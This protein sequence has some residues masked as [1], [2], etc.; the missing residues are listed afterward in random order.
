[1]WVGRFRGVGEVRIDP[2]GGI[3]V[4]CES[5][6]PTAEVGLRHGWADL[7][8]FAR[9]GVRLLAGTA[10]V[11]P[12]GRAVLL[13]GDAATTSEVARVLIEWGWTLLSDRPTPVVF[14]DDTIVAE[15]RP[16]PLLVRPGDGAVTTTGPDDDIPEHTA[17][18]ADTGSADTGSADTTATGQDS[19]PE[20]DSPTIPT[21]PVR[22]DSDVAGLEATRAVGPT[23]IGALVEIAVR[24]VGEDDDVD[25]RGHDRFDH[26]SRLHLAGALRP[27]R[28]AD[29]SVD[30][31]DDGRRNDPTLIDEH[32]RL[33]ALPALRLRFDR[34]GGTDAARRLL[35]WLDRIGEVR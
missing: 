13:T 16:G 29:T 6:D 1:M 21:T 3:E 28:P 32:L 33:A 2:D 12:G 9:R 22:P 25:L 5:E 31:R 20:A 27:D 7:L 35:A 23:A 10:L 18:S 15:P 24:H 14:A 8:S 26:A 19:R 11:R 34:G 4:R 30:E 17:G